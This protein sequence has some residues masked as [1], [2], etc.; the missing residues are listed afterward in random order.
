MKT[1]DLVSLLAADTLPVPP[2]AAPRRLALALVAG[3]P[4]SAA[5]ML[6]KF[7]VR[8][9]I[10]QAV[11]LPMFWPQPPGEDRDRQPVDQR[12]PDP[13]EGVRQADP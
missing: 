11:L 4:L 10:G 7:G 8:D 5:F 9:D 6:L 3:L 1:D 2:Q 12:R 13:L